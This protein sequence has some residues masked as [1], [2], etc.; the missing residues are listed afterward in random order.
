MRIYN[1]FWFSPITSD[2]NHDISHKKFTTTTNEIPI[3]AIFL[4]DN[5]K[6]YNNM[7]D[8]KSMMR[9]VPYVL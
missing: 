5:A 9:Y 4:L 1:S 8:K 2:E 7:I 6:I 3:L